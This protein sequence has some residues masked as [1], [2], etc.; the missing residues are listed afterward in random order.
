MAE[1]EA[2]IPVRAT[3]LPNLFSDMCTQIVHDHNLSRLQTRCQNLFY[4]DLK[5]GAIRRPLKNERFGVDPN[6]GDT[7]M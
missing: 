3:G 4:V 5:D 2:G 1:T 6:L 7:S